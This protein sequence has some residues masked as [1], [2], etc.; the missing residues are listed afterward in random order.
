[1]SAMHEAEGVVTMLSPYSVSETLD[2]LTVL[3]NEHG[4]TI[5]ARIDHSGEAEKVGLEMPPTQL[6][7]FGNPKGG[8]PAMLEAPLT[9]I[10]LPLKAL[11]WADRDGNVFLS[12]ND[13]VYLKHR[14]GLSDDALQPLK[15]VGHLMEQALVS[16]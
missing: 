10:D 11:A 4:V 8:T 6:L 9:A 16:R 12:F 7:I 15:G 13:P 3:L 2:N 14:F 1:M 5:F